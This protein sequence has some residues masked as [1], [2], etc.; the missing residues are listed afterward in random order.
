MGGLSMAESGTDIYIDP[1]KVRETATVLKEQQLKVGN[2]LNEIYSNAIS[3]QNEWQGE[4]ATAYQ[5]IMKK[6]ADFPNSETTAKFINNAIMEYIYDL[7]KIAG[8]FADTEIKLDVKNEA[9]PGDI[10]GV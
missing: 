7:E 1:A 3:M 4:S 2:C 8:E 6:I 10:F 9:L 5:D